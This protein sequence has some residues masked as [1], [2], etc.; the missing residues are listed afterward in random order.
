MLHDLTSS[1]YL[2]ENFL[3]FDGVRRVLG[4]DRLSSINVWTLT[5]LSFYCRSRLRL[6]HIVFLDEIVL[7]PTVK[8]IAVLFHLV[9][10]VSY[11]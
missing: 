11:W 9:L 1:L 4:A 3:N 2:V 10:L 5:T 8:V 7:R 6:S